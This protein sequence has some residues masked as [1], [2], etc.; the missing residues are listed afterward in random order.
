MVLGTIPEWVTYPE[1]DWKSITP[2][3]AGLDPDGWKRFL[4]TCD[5]RGASQDDSGQTGPNGARRLTGAA[6]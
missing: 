5:A 2:Q 3:E 1:D 6:T 4:D